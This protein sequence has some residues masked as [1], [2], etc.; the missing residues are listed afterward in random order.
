MHNTKKRIS[1]TLG[2]VSLVGLTALN[3][4][5][6]NG[7]QLTLN[8][9]KESLA[10]CFVLHT[11]DATLDEYVMTG[12]ALDSLDCAEIEDSGPGSWPREIHIDFGPGCTDGLDVRGKAKCS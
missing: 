11:L 10:M 4:C 3:S 8:T 1:W 7:R 12:E 2:M 6:M 9:A 5:R